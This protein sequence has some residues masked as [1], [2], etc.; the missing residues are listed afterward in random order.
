M[1]RKKSHTELGFS[2]DIVTAV[3]YATPPCVSK[4]VAESCSDFVTTVLMQVRTWI[5]ILLMDVY[6][7][8]ISFSFV[9]LYVSLRCRMT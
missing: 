3:G 1:M 8:R 4:E 7:L 5:T 6:Y 2:P 9:S